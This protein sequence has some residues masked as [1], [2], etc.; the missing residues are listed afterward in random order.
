[1]ERNPYVLLGLPFGASRDEATIALARRGKKL[2]RAPNGAA[3]LTDLTWAHNQI[4]EVIRDPSLAIGIYRIPAD[5]S[6]LEP[7]G[8]TGLLHP[9]PEPLERRTESIA[10]ERDEL[11]LRAGLEL[12][13]AMAAE[14][15]RFVALPDR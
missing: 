2:R 7:K 5:P 9:P 11:V 14:S 4:D 10:E 6:V 15:A 8:Q 3:A 12:I 1:M 13:R